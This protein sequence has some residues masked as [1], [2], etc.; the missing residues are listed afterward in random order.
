VTN[1]YAPVDPA[2]FRRDVSIGGAHVAESADAPD[3][4]QLL[5]RLFRRHAAG[6]A[7]VTVAR[8]GGPSGL[9]V[10]S[11]ASVC[12]EPPLLSFNVAH[13]ASAWPALRAAEQLGVHLL[14]AGQAD[15]AARFARSGADRFGPATRWHWHPAGVPRLDGCP[16]WA[17]TRVHQ[18]VPAGD[19]VIVL[20]ELL[21][22]DADGPAAPLLHHDG[23]FRQL[24]PGPPSTERPAPRLRTVPAVRGDDT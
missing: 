6:V 7:G 16:G 10:T 11:L 15:L 5:R 8:A 3:P 13:S 1:W 23:R 17:L 4:G 12:T 18:H 14:G 20:A 9:L 24:A 19:H 21:E 2:S 22:V